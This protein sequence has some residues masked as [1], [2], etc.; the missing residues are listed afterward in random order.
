MLFIGICRHFAFV[1]QFVLTVLRPKALALDFRIM[2]SDFTGFMHRESMEH[3]EIEAL[4]DKSVAKI[5]Q[6][7][8][9]MLA[10]ASLID[11]TRGLMLTPAM[12]SRALAKVVAKTDINQLRWLLVA[13]EDIRHLTQ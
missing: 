7:L 4:T 8:L 5:R 3:D 9:R 2:P 11:S 13:D 10:E 6:V 12:P 1:R